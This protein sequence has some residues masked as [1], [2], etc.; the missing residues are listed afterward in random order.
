MNDRE[1]AGAWRSVSVLHMYHDFLL[2]YEH[3]L[4]TIIQNE[5]MPFH[6]YNFPEVRCTRIDP[7]KY[8]KMHNTC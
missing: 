2:H 7:Q 3:M 5:A 6:A 1:S 4:L 8:I